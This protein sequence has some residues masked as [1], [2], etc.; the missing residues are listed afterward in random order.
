MAKTLP[1]D[2]RKPFAIMRFGP[3]YPIFGEEFSFR[4]E[5]AAVFRDFP[6]LSLRDQ[7]MPLIGPVHR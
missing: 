1:R 7:A 3:I 6:R 5:L 4:E 2:R